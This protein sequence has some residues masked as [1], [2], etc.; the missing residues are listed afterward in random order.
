MQS[1]MAVA[2]RLKR[3]FSRSGRSRCYGAKLALANRIHPR[4]QAAT[5]LIGRYAGRA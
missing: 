1:A 4:H 5:R 2:T 3:R